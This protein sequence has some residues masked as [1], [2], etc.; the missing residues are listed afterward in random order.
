[1]TSRLIDNFK[2][3]QAMAEIDRLILSGSNVEDIVRHA[4]LLAGE[5]SARTCY[6]YLKEDGDEAAHGQLYEIVENVLNRKDLVLPMSAEDKSATSLLNAL[7][8]SIGRKCGEAFEIRVDSAK[9]GL[10]FV[11]EEALLAEAHRKTLSELA[12]RISVAVTNS[13]R[14]DTLYR[15][16]N[17]DALTG[18]INRQAFS[19]R[20][21][22]RL[23]SAI[24]GGDRGGLLFLDLDRFKQVNDTQGHLVGDEL[25]REVADRLSRTLRS[26]DTVA[27]LGGDEFAVIVSEF[28]SDTEL[29]VLCRRII[30]AINKP[31]ITGN[32]SHEVDVSIGVSIFPNDG[33]DTATLLMKADV[34]MYKAKEVS[35]S[36]FAFFDQSLNEATEKR[37]L[38]EGRLRDALSSNKLRLHFQPKLNLKTGCVDSVEGLMRWEG[39]ESEVYSPVDFVPV[40]ED[41]GLIHQFTEILVTDAA[42]CLRVSH[43]EGFDIQRIAVNISTRQFA[44]EGFA[45][46]FLD[47]ISRSSAD[48]REFE[49]EVTESLFIDDAHR[50]SEELGKLKAAGIH[51][52]LD[53]FG[54]GFSSL[55]MLRSLP[56]DTLKID[57]SFIT[58]FTNSTEARTLVQ[59]IVEIAK[60]LNLSVVAEGVEEQAQVEL[61]RSFGCDYIQGFVLSPALSVPDLVSYLKSHAEL[62]AVRSARVLP[63]NFS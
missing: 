16:A 7:S 45:D 11:A 6:V 22:D 52:A 18:L 63:L 29:T 23:E 27:R 56:L 8:R 24:R 14:A 28:E 21:A 39:E 20:L 48:A 59:K 46:S 53:D 2:K 60:A 55:N 31:I 19:D 1:M 41:T 50:V 57:R 33:Q 12:D 61:L 26:V 37:A 3:M 38:I 49:I 36:A 44:F 25:L 13:Q 32:I 15:Q 5:D 42:E 4:L 58:Q 34:A 10:L 47:A 9:A 54:T 43:A 51:I 35:G 40:A 62:S 30:S 17:Y